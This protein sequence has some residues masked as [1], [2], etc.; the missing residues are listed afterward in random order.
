M[1]L[2]GKDVSQFPEINRMF[3]AFLKDKPAEK[4]IKAFEKYVAQR[5][6]FPTVADILAIVEERIKLDAD[7]YRKVRRKIEKG[8]TT[9]YAEDDYIRKYEL[10][11]T[12]EWE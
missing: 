8:E 6:K 4:V 9:S 3:Q 12:K 10:Q 7:Y 11:T 5:S 2:Y 1:E